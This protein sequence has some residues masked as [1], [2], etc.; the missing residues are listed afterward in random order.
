MGNYKPKARKWRENGLPGESVNTGAPLHVPQ[1]HRRVERGARQDQV[2]V[3]VVGACWVTIY[4]IFK[5][6]SFK[7]SERLTGIFI[8]VG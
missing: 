1:P 5:V 7:L 6:D 3:G 8:S 4:G 2:H